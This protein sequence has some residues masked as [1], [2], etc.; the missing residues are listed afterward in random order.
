MIRQT[1]VAGLF[2][3]SDESLLT[4]NI[5]SMID[6]INDE[7]ISDEAT[8]KSIVVPHAGY[9]YSGRTACYA[10]NELTKD[11]LPETF[12]IIGPNHTGIGDRLSLS[13][14]KKWNTPLGDIDV[15][16]E[17]INKLNEVDLNC[18]LD[19]SAHI[20]EHS[21]EVELPF[22]Q[23][24]AGKKNTDFKIVPII[25]K[26]QHPQLCKDLARSIH[27]A[28]KQLD[29]KI[30]IIAST[31]LT[32][33][34]DAD[35]AKFYDSKVMKAIENMDSDDLFK[36]IVE[37]DITMCGYGPTITAMEYSKLIGAKNSYI[38]KYSNSGD[39]SG[40]YDSVVGYTSAMIR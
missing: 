4:R 9:V 21:I 31:D 7:S 12:V 32:H 3:E 1:C 10:F 40:D 28:S 18:T 30:I 33:Y 13:T 39:V 6:S 29:R 8:I 27:E 19:E 14:S 36:Q 38:L 34:E 35:T 22:L 17:F 16:V 11:D 26:Y 24:I 2:Y 5:E 23:Y 15:D 37:Y 25:I 20:R